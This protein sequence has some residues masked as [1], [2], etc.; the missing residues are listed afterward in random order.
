MR[1]PHRYEVFGSEEASEFELEFDCPA[2]G[3]AA[4]SIEQRLLLACQFD[5]TTALSFGMAGDI[6]PRKCGTRCG[7]RVSRTR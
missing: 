2:R 6:A 4:V 1:R 7:F 5:M 3:L